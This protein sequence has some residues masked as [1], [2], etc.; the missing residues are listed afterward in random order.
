M[1]LRNRIL[2]VDDDPLN[3]SILE[4]VLEEGFVIAAAASGAEALRVA[5]EFKPDL[6][7]LDI[8]MP[9]MDG[10]ETCRRLR[11]S[12][13]SRFVK[14]ILV[15]A[16]AMLS[17]RLKGY[18]AGADDYVTKPFDHSEL[19]AKVKVF[20]R[21]KSTEEISQLKTDFLVLLSHE[22][23]TPLNH[24]LAPAELLAMEGDMEAEERKDLSQMIIAGA[25]RLRCLF[26]EAMVYFSFKTGR[27]HLE[28]GTVDLGPLA[29][30][31]V[32]AH[33]GS[34]CGRGVKVNLH[35]HEGLVVPGDG[36]S[37]RTL[38][39]AAINQATASAPEGQEI[40]LA[41]TATETELEITAPLDWEG[42]DPAA[43][44]ALFE[45]FQ[46]RD[47]RHHGTQINLELPLIREIAVHHGGSVSAGLA[48]S[49]RRVLC[50]RL[51]LTS[52][53]QMAA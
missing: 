14:I 49:G 43:A 31:V 29:L 48:G 47:L 24:I 37:I 33:A 7:L 32:R 1:I 40:T 35:G 2:I 45:V 12:P 28:N 5:A 18:E 6:L 52:G 8:M 19:L 34:T 17:E 25:E 21:L 13:E 3:V 4:E 53:E 10:Y 27:I 9:E 51:P 23:R 38:L 36:A 30:E 41:F 26:E 46:V 42:D 22:T 39:A 20:L 11:Q 50:V 44:R 15:S 16:K